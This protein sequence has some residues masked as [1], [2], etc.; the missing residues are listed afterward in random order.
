MRLLLI[1]FLATS[2]FTHVAVSQAASTGD[3][4]A[5][6]NALMKSTYRDERVEFPTDSY[7]VI[8]RQTKIEDDL[9][10][11]VAKNHRDLAASFIAANKY[12]ASLTSNLDFAKYY[13]VE[14]QEINEYFE[15]AQ[16]EI[17][18]IEAEAKAQNAGVIILPTN[19]W[20]LFHQ[21]YPNAY[22][23]YSLSRV[24]FSRNK[25]YALVQIVRDSAL[26][27][28]SRTYLLR[29]VKGTWEPITWS[30]SS[31]IS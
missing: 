11:D 7:Y 16:A 27:G 15:K 9:H 18:A 1:T 21:K 30:G 29:K 28:Y 20:R 12:P 10:L 22:G 5:V 2:L 24:G 3:E 19:Y 26:T 14:E 17:K 13:L 23:L 31:S 8:Y 6:Y 25:E 4:C